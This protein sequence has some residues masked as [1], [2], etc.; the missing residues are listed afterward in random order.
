MQILFGICIGALLLFLMS[1]N[2]PSDRAPE[3]CGVRKVRNEVQVSYVLKGPEPQTCIQP[4]AEPKAE[5]EPSKEPPVIL[6]PKRHVKHRRH[7]RHW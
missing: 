2:T 4:V 6:K 1:P 5:V 3:D 7:R